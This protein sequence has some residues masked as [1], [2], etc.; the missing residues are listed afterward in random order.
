M[1]KRVL[2]FSALVALSLAFT[3]VLI[4]KALKTEKKHKSGLSEE[5]SIW[6]ALKYRDHL[7]MNY[8]TGRVEPS[9]YY[10]AVKQALALRAAGSRAGALG[11][12]WE[13][14]GPDNV[15]GRTR[16][17]LVDKDDS[18]I[19]WAGGA[20][21]GLWQSTDEGESWTLVEGFRTATSTVYNSIGCIA[22]GK[23]DGTIYVGTGEPWAKYSSSYMPGNGVY[24]S[25]DRG[26]TWTHC[27]GSGIANDSVPEFAGRWSVVSRMAVDP[28]DDLHVYAAL[29]NGGL[30]E[31]K[32]GGATWAKPSA[33][34]TNTASNDVH[35]AADGQ[36]IWAVVATKQVYR[37]VDNG[38]N[39]VN[40]TGTTGLATLLNGPSP[41]RV[42]LA[43]APSDQNYV[44]ILASASCLQGVYRTT[45][46][47]ITWQTL[48]GRGSTLDPFSQPLPSS[49]GGCQGGY[50]DCIAVVP[51][52][53]TKIY[54]GG[55]VLYCYSDGLSWKRADKI[56][57]EGGGYDDPSYIHAD[58]HFITFDPHN[59]ERMFVT[60]DGGISRSDNAN[61][62]FPTPRFKSIDK[63]YNAIQFY[64]IAAST[65][66]EVL[67]GAQDNGTRYIDFKGNTIRASKQVMGGDGFFCEFSHLNTNIMFGSVYFADMKRSGNKGLS[68][69]EV[70]DS[71]IDP[72]GSGE[73][74]SCSNCNPFVTT[75]FLSET[76]TAYN[77]ERTVPFKNESP[78]VLT[79]GTTVQVTSYTSNITFPYTLTADLAVGATVNVKDP[80]D[81]KLFLG[82]STAATPGCGVWM[83]YN[84]LNISQQPKWY[85]VPIANTLNAFCSSADGNVA[86][87]GCGNSVYRVSGL[88][89]ANYSAAPVITG[90]T[91]QTIS[92]PGSTRP[93]GGIY[94]DR[95]DSNHVV[96]TRSGYQAGTGAVLKSTDGV[97]F[98]DITHNLPQMPVYDV[99]I[100]SRNRNNYVIGTEL[101]FWG[102]DNAGTSWS[103]ENT[104][105][106]FTPIYR[107]RQEGLYEDGCPVIYGGA[108]GRGFWRTTTLLDGTS[109]R[110]VAGMDKPNVPNANVDFTLFPNPAYEVANI[111]LSLE[112]PAQVEI[113][114]VDMPGRIVKRVK[115]EGNSGNNQFSVNLDGVPA[116]SYVAAIRIGG[117]SLK[118]KVFVK[119]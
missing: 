50:D 10:N 79:S 66:G 104:N 5:Q 96:I 114:I 75:F 4:Q 101:G 30:Y 16:A 103:E 87:F 29:E 34:A 49:L 15:G 108:H 94:V 2:L 25:T 47:G 44:Y 27:A 92:L 31:T 110:L 21:G 56:G 22:Q 85:K 90:L 23:K 62:G 37:S 17:V 38:L 20:S 24:K 100:D 69:S 111:S 12:N 40:V 54:V 9:D 43:L 107:L 91:I 118:S 35:Y 71:N 18:H 19:L 53:K 48:L 68:F 78:D 93:I 106:G 63:G 113:N 58:K 11:L 33:I 115:F 86:Y 99:V 74:G 59:P 98:T 14:I 51:N 46:G 84:P 41:T 117:I 97:T 77:N 81:A 89:T 28:N 65:A 39:W 105:F 116:G 6:E 70:F 13:E 26:V 119:R 102:S 76:R 57:S 3:P 61:S 45:D 109:C 73:P 1:K 55:V 80:I 42:E 64:S 60:H 36:T 83:L 88:N 52:D 67:G 72:D 8:G 82:T 95:N 32:D 112:K 7:T